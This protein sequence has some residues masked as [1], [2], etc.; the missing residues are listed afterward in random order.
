MAD[1]TTGRTDLTIELY[2]C[3]IF[4]FEIGDNPNFPQPEGRTTLI[5]GVSDT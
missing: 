4:K 1:I 3:D 5:E 2:V